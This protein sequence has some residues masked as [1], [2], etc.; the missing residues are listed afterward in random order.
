MGQGIEST[1]CIARRVE[2]RSS[3]L[4]HIRASSGNAIALILDFSRTLR[5]STHDID[6]IYY[7][8]LL[9]G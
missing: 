2:N 6:A 7:V 8:P 5:A 9:S 3:P 4:L 1:T